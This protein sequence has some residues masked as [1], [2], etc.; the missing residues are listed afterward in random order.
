MAYGSDDGE[1]EDLDANAFLA[2]LKRNRLYKDAL[3]TAGATVAV[4]QQAALL[5][6]TVTQALLRAHVLRPSP[7]LRDALVTDCGRGVRLVAEN[8]CSGC[9]C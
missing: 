9:C 1:D 3:R 5:G 2:L 8:G 6:L 4:P 7:Y